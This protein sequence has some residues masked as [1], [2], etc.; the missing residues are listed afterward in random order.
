MIDF[1]ERA[2][3]AKAQSASGASRWQD[4]LA[5][6]SIAGLLLPEAVAYSGIA[7]LPPQAGV[8]ALFAGLLC[9]GLFGSSRFAIVSATS[10]SAAVLAAATM[11]MSGGDPAHRMVLAVGLV[12]LTGIA[13]FLAGLGRVGGITHF[14]ARPVLQGFAFGLALVIIVKQLAVI[15]G[16]HPLDADMV[17][18]LIDLCGRS[19]EWHPASIALGLA[20]IILLFALGRLKRIPGAVVVILLG[21]AVGKWLG[22]AQYGI[23]L[24][25]PIGLTLSIPTI[26][27]LSPPEWLRLA[28]LAIA[29]VLVLY[30]EAYGAIRTFAMK[31][32]DSISPNRDL[33]ALGAANLLS[34]L[35]HGM[36]VGAGY[37]ATSAN[38]AAGAVSRLAGWAATAVLFA[39]VATLLPFIE[40]MPQPVLA[41]IVIHAVSHTLTFGTFRSYFQWERDRLIVVSSVLAVIIF[42]ILDGLL[43]AIGI[44]LFMMLRHLSGSKVVVL[45]RL[46]QGHDYV[47]CALHPQAQAVPGILILRPE[48]ALFF[49]NAE[50]IIMQAQQYL[51]EGGPAVDTVI[52]SLEESPDLDSTSLQALDEFRKFV[53]AQN[54]QLIFARVKPLVHDAL[55]R[56]SEGGAPKPYLSELSVDD[57]VATAL[58][59]R[60]D[61]DGERR[62]AAASD[63]HL[64]RQVSRRSE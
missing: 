40:L 64:S 51:P 57:A 5:G 9:Y 25:G 58:R 23:E 4:V 50:R 20:S 42:G 21:I 19:D 35:F 61:R 47:D 31:H 39:V 18:A 46:G 16:I 30:A 49:A 33:L 14:I 38:E 56:L 7:N 63:L 37:S 60:R 28:E 8:I 41:A 45:G 48:E 27:R 55:A 54:S 44:S 29:L 36:P 3:L 59:L 10:S 62:A 53:A 6:L 15:A 22:L 2:A 43:A 52:L 11:S 26:P 12:L 24:V 1:S 32:G 34:G 17:R 13:F